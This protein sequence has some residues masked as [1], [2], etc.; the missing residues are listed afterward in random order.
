MNPHTVA[1]MGLGEEGVDC[2]SAIRSLEQLKLIAVGD[3]EAERLRRHTESLSLRTYEDYRSL[4]LETSHAGLDVLIVSLEPF[5]SLEFVEM[6]ASRGIAVFHKAPWART[7]AEARR[8]I[9]L[10]AKRSCPLVVSRWWQFEPAFE[11]LADMAQQCGHVFA[12]T[13]SIHTNDT[14][15]G[16]RGDARRAGGGVLLNG[17]YEILD[18]LVHV[19]GMPE[20]V[21]A[22]CG[23]GT[24]PGSARSYD[25]EDFAYL[26]LCLP[27][28]RKAS[29][30]C[31]RG[32]A[33][34]D[35]RVSF[36]G[37]QGTVEVSQDR[38]IY[39]PRDGGAPQQHKVWAK[40]PIVHAIG[41]FA[42]TLTDDRKSRQ[43][44]AKEHL[45]TVA[46]IQAAYL[47][48]KTGEPESPSRMLD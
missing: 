27:H 11:P 15:A 12:A 44:T 19:M 28:D 35:W 9:D 20:S 43:S 26:S 23:F 40:Y 7:V 36:Y 33:E 34:S 47:S 18:M 45:A 24:E 21:Y 5:Q 30:V 39:T 38:L 42:E 22:Q 32:A 48:A 8:L 10:F 13:A 14:S 29:V 41:A 17:A 3:S 4:I 16:W 37:T 31:S 46:L 25:T 1:L 6:A 2:L